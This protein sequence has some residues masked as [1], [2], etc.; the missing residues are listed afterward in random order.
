MLPR[1]VLAISLRHP[2]NGTPREA[3]WL[4]LT[5]FL[6]NRGISDDRT[7]GIEILYDD[8]ESTAPERRRFDACLSVPR[9]RIAG[10]SLLDR[11][12]D[13]LGIRVL[14]V[15]DE[16]LLLWWGGSAHVGPPVRH[17]HVSVAAGPPL[18]ASWPRYRIYRGSPV[19]APGNPE[20]VGWYA[21][22]A[23]AV[24]QEGGHLPPCTQSGV[25]RRPY[26]AARRVSGRGLRS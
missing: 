13:S 9:D 11:R 22:A 12:R 26:R 24:P 14:P 19:L 25:P 23:P 2:S 21:T 10:L 6:F 5:A 1:P 3:T 20:T 7:V 4:R 8:P 16:R 17:R 15:L 18:R